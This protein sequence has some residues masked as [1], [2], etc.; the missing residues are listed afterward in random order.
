MK[1]CWSVGA[2]DTLQR[3]HR[4]LARHRYR[5]LPVVDNGGVLGI[6]SER[7]VLAF[8]ALRADTPWW[9]ARSR[10]A[11]REVLFTARP[12]EL[13]DVVVDRIIASPESVVVVLENSRLAGLVTAGDVL[14]AE[15]EETTHER[16]APTA[17]DVMTETLVSVSPT[18]SLTDASKLMAAHHIRHL[19]V[20]DHGRLIGMISERDLLPVADEVSSELVPPEYRTLLKVRDAM[21]DAVTTVTRDA[22]LGEVVRTLI[23]RKIGAIPVVDADEHPVGIVSYIDVLSALAAQ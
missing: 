16:E 20:I 11:M 17:G 14:A 10:D 13:V 21:R 23:A 5:H 7:D 2:D 19:L 6:L 4:L 8:R 3:A 9:T 12:D 18:D 1:P 22:T 15:L